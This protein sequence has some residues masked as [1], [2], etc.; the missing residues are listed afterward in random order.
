VSGGGQLAVTALVGAG[1]IAAGWLA[2]RWHTRRKVRRARERRDGQIAALDARQKPN[3]ATNGPG[4]L[5]PWFGRHTAPPRPACACWACALTPAELGTN[6][7]EAHLEEIYAR[8]AYE[9]P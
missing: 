5:H 2:D 9:R 7:C 4:D 1:L 8:D 6:D 3:T